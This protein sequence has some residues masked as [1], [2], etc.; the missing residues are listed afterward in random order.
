M[1]RGIAALGRRFRI[2][3]LIYIFIVTELSLVQPA[4]SLPFGV[5]RVGKCMCAECLQTITLPSMWCR[6]TTLTHWGI[7][8]IGIISIQHVDPPALST[9]AGLKMTFKI[10]VIDCW[11]FSVELLELLWTPRTKMAEVALQAPNVVAGE[12]AWGEP[13]GTPNGASDTIALCCKALGMDP[14]PENELEMPDINFL[15]VRLLNISHKFRK[16]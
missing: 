1:M 15:Q 8:L 3:A 2:G 7:S 5:F 14:N 12:S 6:G 13:E 11:D 16:S 10:T 9:N 4:D